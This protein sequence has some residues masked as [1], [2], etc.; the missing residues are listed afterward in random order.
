M[1]DVL[2]TL[3]VPEFASDAFQSLISLPECVESQFDMLWLARGGREE[4]G[5]CEVSLAVTHRH[6]HETNPSAKSIQY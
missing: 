3:R 4:V 1:R 2:R 6:L 5:G